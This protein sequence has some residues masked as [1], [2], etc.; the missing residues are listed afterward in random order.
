MRHI[1]FTLV[2]LLSLVFMTSYAQDD[3]IK[4]GA[5]E[6][7][8]MIGGY[9]NFGDPNKVNIEVNVWGYVKNSGKYLVP[10]GT[11]LLDLI[12][13]A[14][15]PATDA[16]LDKIRVYRPKNDSLGITKDKIF[17]FD[18]NDLI[19][20]EKVKDK[21]YRVNPEIEP[22]DMVILPGSPRYFFRENLTFIMSISSF[23]L[24]AA[25]LIV[26]VTKK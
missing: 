15:G 9:F 5:Y 6:R 12:T 13:Y 1:N 16:D 4:V 23:L 10:R 14:G 7:Q 2:I 11:T 26:S 3:K 21:D 25:I 22:G 24:S 17:Y 20:E 19:W 8:N 18:Y